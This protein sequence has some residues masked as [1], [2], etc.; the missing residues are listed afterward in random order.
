M[1]L[2]AEFKEVDLVVESI[3]GEGSNGNACRIRYFYVNGF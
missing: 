1:K 3:K 2:A